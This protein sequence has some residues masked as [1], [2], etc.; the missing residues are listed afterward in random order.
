MVQPEML[1]RGLAGSRLRGVRNRTGQPLD[2]ADDIWVK[3][4]AGQMA[5]ARGGDIAE[6]WRPARIVA[7]SLDGNAA[8]VCAQ[9]IPRQIGEGA[10]GPRTEPARITAGQ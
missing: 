3:A 6:D 4:P 8:G 7:G 5:F 9:R 10:V 1:L 2:A